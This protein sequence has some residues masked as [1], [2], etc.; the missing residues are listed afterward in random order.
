MDVIL[1]FKGGEPDDVEA[2][3]VAL[4]GHKFLASLQDFDSWLR[5]KHRN[6]VNEGDN[7]TDGDVFSVRDQF[8]IICAENGV[9][10]WS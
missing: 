9:D 8:A 7:F 4:D 5:G 2:A 3:R 10:L 1:H 6:G